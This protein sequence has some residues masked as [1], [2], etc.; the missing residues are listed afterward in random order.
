[1]VAMTRACTWH[2]AAPAEAGDDALL[3]HAQELGLHVERHVAD[4]VE[5]DGAA[6]G[7]LEL[8]RVALGAGAREGALL[9]AEEL[10]LEQ[11]PWARRRS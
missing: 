6:R 11:L 5:Q 10:R 4:L 8:A 1:M 9:V 2:L 3:E 7:E